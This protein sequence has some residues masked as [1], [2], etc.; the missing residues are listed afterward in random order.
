MERRPCFRK[1]F[2][3]AWVAEFNASRLCSCECGFCA[4]RNHLA[5]MLGN[6][7]QYVD[8]QPV[9]GWHIDRDELHVAV[10]QTGDE[11]DVTGK[12]VKLGDDKRCS[13]LAA[14]IERGHQLRAV[15]FLTRLN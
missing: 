11:V 2:M 15:R 13:M 4:L 7:G 12:A 8:G 10:H 5:L 9:G 1:C 6:C 14:V 3:G